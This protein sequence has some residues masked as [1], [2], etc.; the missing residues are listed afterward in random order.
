MN[1]YD[2]RDDGDPAVPCL[3]DAG[4]EILNALF[5]KRPRDEGHERR[6]DSRARPPEEIYHM[7][8]VVSLVLR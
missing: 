3:V 4:Y 8:A 7:A 5:W 1:R 6:Y 2:T